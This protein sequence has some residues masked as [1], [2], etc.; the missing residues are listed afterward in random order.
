MLLATNVIQNS[1]K[2]V[3]IISVVSKKL[4][5]LSDSVLI[6]RLQEQPILH[7]MPQ[8]MNIAAD[9][10]E[11]LH[12][13]CIGNQKHLLLMYYCHILKTNFPWIPWIMMQLFSTKLGTIG[14]KRH[15]TIKDRFYTHSNFLHT[16]AGSAYFNVMYHGMIG[17]IHTFESHIEGP[18]VLLQSRFHFCPKMNSLSYKL[19]STHI[20]SLLVS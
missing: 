16:F 12:T 6:G 18:L 10:C 14:L 3:H 8:I 19:Y 1:C 11:T 9:F 7:E 15:V 5:D 20:H 17:I 2:S 4:S 13:H